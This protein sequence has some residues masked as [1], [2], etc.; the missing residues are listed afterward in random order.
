[1][2]F[3]RPSFHF[4]NHLTDMF[5]NPNME[6]SLIKILFDF[7]FKAPDLMT[8]MNTNRV[9]PNTMSTLNGIL[10]IVLHQIMILA[11]PDMTAAF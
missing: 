9:F 4:Q 8:W 1:M 10:D 5:F 7:D 11:V 2:Q 3:Y 6:G